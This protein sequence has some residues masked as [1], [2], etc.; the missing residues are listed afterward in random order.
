MLHNSLNRCKGVGVGRRFR[1]KGTWVYLWL[2]HTA[3][4]QKPTE[5]CKAI[6]LQLKKKYVIKKFKN[7][8]GTF[9]GPENTPFPRPCSEWGQE[10][11]VASPVESAGNLFPSEGT[12]LLLLAPTWY[13]R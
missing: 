4:R 3:I 8:V 2:T 1:R 5:H 10:K 13:D 9:R 12:Q 11:G 7:S 6:I